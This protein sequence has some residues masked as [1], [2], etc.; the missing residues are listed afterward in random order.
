MEGPTVVGEAVI[1]CTFRVT[2]KALLC[3]LQKIKSWERRNLACL[4]NSE[5]ELGRVD[6]LGRC[7]R[8]E[9]PKRTSITFWPNKFQPNMYVQPNMYA[10]LKLVGPNG[11]VLA[12]SEGKYNPCTDTT[13]FYIGER[14]LSEEL[15]VDDDAV[16]KIS[17]Y[18][19]KPGIL[20]QDQPTKRLKDDLTRMFN[21]GKFSD[22]VVNISGEELK[23]HKVILAS[24]SKF[25]AS[26]F[27]SGMVEAQSGIS[28]LDDY[29]PKIMKAMLRYLYSSQLEEIKGPKEKIKFYTELLKAA[30]F[31]QIDSLKTNCEDVLSD[32]ISAE[33]ADELIILAV[34]YRAEKLR[35]KVVKFMSEGHCFCT[36]RLNE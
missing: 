18:E 7:S 24:R 25:F 14:E 17:L 19:F 34:T 33:S 13:G 26:M 2:I 10:G 6:M 3:E 1:C 23:L 5:R 20:L 31:F 32:L 4:T 9:Y 15:K 8:Y 12:R 27:D 21:D 36:R 35:L 30:E 16:L 11:K 22:F 29:E 28:K